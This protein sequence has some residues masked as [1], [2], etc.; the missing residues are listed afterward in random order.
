MSLE[1]KPSCPFIIVNILRILILLVF[2]PISADTEE[3][4]IRKEIFVETYFNFSIVTI[5][6]LTIIS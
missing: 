4:L 1:K 3:R 5:R 2:F 6:A